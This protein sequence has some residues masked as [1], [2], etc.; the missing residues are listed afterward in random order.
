LP[1]DSWMLHG[2][3]AFLQGASAGNGAEFIQ[4]NRVHDSALIVCALHAG[5]SADKLLFII[6]SL[7]VAGHAEQ[8]C[9]APKQCSTYTWPVTAVRMSWHADTPFSPAV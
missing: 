4:F 9:S 7:D 5:H 3:A 6:S 8:R 1:L 2:M